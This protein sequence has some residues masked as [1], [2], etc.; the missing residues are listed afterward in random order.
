ML[1]LL[2]STLFFMLYVN[3]QVVFSCCNSCTVL[4]HCCYLVF[5]KKNVQ[6]LCMKT[7]W[8]SVA[9]FWLVLCLYWPTFYMAPLKG[10]IFLLLLKMFCRELKVM[11]ER[12]SI[13]DMEEQSHTWLCRP[14]THD[15]RVW[16]NGSVSL[17]TLTLK[18]VWFSEWEVAYYRVYMFNCRYSNWVSLKIH[19]KTMSVVS[20]IVLL[21]DK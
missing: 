3:G 17:C 8:N 10:A 6:S 7:V 16:N 1:L 11:Q 15:A 18:L 20:K 21:K 9:G 14:E 13:G 19:F 5:E 12:I 4:Y 2:Y